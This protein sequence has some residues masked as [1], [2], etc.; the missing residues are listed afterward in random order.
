MRPAQATMPIA[1]ARRL[2]HPTPTGRPR[3]VCR[4]RPAPLQRPS[5]VQA[6]PLPLAALQVGAA[7]AR[8]CDAT[9]AAATLQEKV[10]CARRWSLPTLSKRLNAPHAAQLEEPGEVDMVVSCQG[11]LRRA[12]E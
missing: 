4:G 2:Q 8:A 3:F 10:R 12:G 7:V 6:E 11:E 9:P 5:G 1:A